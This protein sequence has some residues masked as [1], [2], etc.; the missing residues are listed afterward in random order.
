MSQSAYSMSSLSDGGTSS[1][2]NSVAI[3]IRSRFASEDDVRE[4]VIPTTFS[5]SDL[6]LATEVRSIHLDKFDSTHSGHISFPSEDDEDDLA[7]HTVDTDHPVLDLDHRPLPKTPHPPPPP[8]V[9][10]AVT[11]ATTRPVSSMNTGNRPHTNSV[12][13]NIEEINLQNAT[14]AGLKGRPLPPPPIRVSPEPLMELLPIDQERPKATVVGVSSDAHPKTVIPVRI[15]PPAP[16]L[17]P[18]PPAKPM[19]RP[20]LVSLEDTQSPIK[21]DSPTA[22][23]VVSPSPTQTSPKEMGRRPPVASPVNREIKAIDVIKPSVDAKQP[24]ALQAP[25]LKEETE[26]DSEKVLSPKE[27]F[28]LLLNK[29]K[30]DAASSIKS[31]ASG[32]GGV[33]P[34]K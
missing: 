29:A 2:R 31:T 6:R 16:V 28:Q 8:P 18:A 12:R 20:S 33:S 19:K 10:V 4:T 25:P 26:R 14:R 23:N 27:A 24:P 21:L 13:F 9:A 11:G 15:I 30:Q 5:E 17:K 34:R 22:A 7:V 3:P 1:N 32:G